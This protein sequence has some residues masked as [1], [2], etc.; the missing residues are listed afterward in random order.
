MTLTEQLYEGT[1]PNGNYYVELQ[2]KSTTPVY[3]YK[4]RS[5]KN[6]VIYR[7]KAFT[8]FITKNQMKSVLEELPTYE[9][10]KAQQDYEG[11]Q[12]KCISVYEKKEKQHTDDAIAY[13]ELE[14]TNSILKDALHTMTRA[15]QISE[16]DCKAL[17]KLVL[18]LSPE[19]KE[20][21][22]KH[23]GEYL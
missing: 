21:L 15:W 2:D 9:E 8:G 19:R 4:M 12:K 14:E 22:E 18:K 17:A 16:K 11:Y 1:L 5:R 7:V 23:Y 10:W 6:K 20:W 13:N 3:M